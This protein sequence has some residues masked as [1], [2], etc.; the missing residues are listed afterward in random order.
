MPTK[1]TVCFF[2]Q[3]FWVPEIL[4]ESDDKYEKL[5]FQ[6]VTVNSHAKRNP[7]KTGLKYK[8][9]PSQKLS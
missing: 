7:I 4:K 5:L 3:K 2:Q 1:S 9:Q 8:K 6:G